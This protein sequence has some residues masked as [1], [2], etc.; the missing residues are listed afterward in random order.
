EAIYNTTSGGEEVRWNTEIE[1]IT[2]KPGT[3]YLHVFN[4]PEDK[5]V[6]LNDFNKQVETIYLLA[7]KSK[8]PLKFKTHPQGVM[9]TLPDTPLD[10]INNIIV[11]KYEL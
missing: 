9:I 2:A 7:D 8:N 3:F 11:V 1:M 6:Y 10:A 5:K 4:Y